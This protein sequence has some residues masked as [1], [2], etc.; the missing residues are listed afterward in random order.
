MLSTSR[1]FLSLLLEEVY[2]WG[3]LRKGS[4]KLV[5]RLHSSDKA[6]SVVKLNSGAPLVHL[7]RRSVHFTTTSLKYQKSHH[8][9]SED[10]SG[11]MCT[12]QTMEVSME[13]Y[14]K[15]ILLN[16][17]CHCFNASSTRC[18]YIKMYPLVFWDAFFDVPSN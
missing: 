18:A 4:V 14:I 6:A 17:C 12:V 2:S 7:F 1:L 5:S 16:S 11:F 15:H 9:F 10:F 13:L 3:R 8:V